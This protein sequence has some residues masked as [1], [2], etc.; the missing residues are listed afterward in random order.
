MATTESGIYVSGEATTRNS[1]C[2][3]LPTGPLS[4]HLIVSTSSRVPDLVWSFFVTC[5][6][7][8]KTVEPH[9]LGSNWPVLTFLELVLGPGGQIFTKQTANIEE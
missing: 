7:I 5:L 2:I 9:E 8:S 3:L 4:P 1:L 6:G